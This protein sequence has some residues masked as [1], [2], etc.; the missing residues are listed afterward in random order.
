MYTSNNFNFGHEKANMKLPPG[1]GVTD[2][3]YLR[4]ILVSYNIVLYTLGE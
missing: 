2:I 1:G 3:V 4:F